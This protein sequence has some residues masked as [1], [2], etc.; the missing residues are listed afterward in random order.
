MKKMRG[1]YPEEYETIKKAIKEELSFKV[2]VRQWKRKY[3]YGAIDIKPLKANGWALSKEEI[4]EIYALMQ[5]HGLCIDRE[6]Y[7]ETVPHYDII[8]RSGVCFV[9]KEIA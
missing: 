8:F 1:L 3:A 6:N 2:S 4:D 9:Y 7:F 5:R